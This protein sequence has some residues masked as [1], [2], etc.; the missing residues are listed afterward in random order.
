[1]TQVKSK[2]DSASI[3]KTIGCKRPGVIVT[4]ITEPSYPEPSRGVIT[5]PCASCTEDCQ[6]KGPNKTFTF[7]NVIKK[8]KIEKCDPDN[9]PY[10]I[11]CAECPRRDC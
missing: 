3:A 7:T 4:K 1:M 8:P 5:V 11:P 10:D 9:C 6:N 2:S